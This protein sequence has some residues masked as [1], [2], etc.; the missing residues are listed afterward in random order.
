MFE[1]LAGPIV[2]RVTENRACIWLAA[3]LESALKLSILD[4][5]GKVLGVSDPSDLDESRCRLG[6]NLY[7][8]L[9]QARPCEGTFPENALLHYRIDR[10]EGDAEVPIDLAE[11]GLTY[12]GAQHPSFFLP[13]RLKRILYGSCRKPHGLE[14]LFAADPANAVTDGLSHGDAELERTHADLAL[15]PALLVLGGDQIYADDVAVSL[16]EMLKP[17]ATRLLGY[18]EQIP[19]LPNPA[20][21]APNGRKAA[22]KRAGF[23]SEEADN[24]LLGFGEFAA[25][26]LYA[27]GNAPAWTPQLHL[28][29]K[30]KRK[31]AVESFHATLPKVRRLLAN[32]PTYMIFDDHDVTDDWNITAAWYNRVRDSAA[33]R[34]VTA[35]AL[36]AYW[37][38][39]AW[40]NDPDNFDRDLRWAIE[41]FIADDR[42]CTGDLADR[43]DLQLW[44]H[45]GWG[46]SIPSNPPIV[47]I[48]SRTQRQPDNDYNPPKLLDRYA[49][50]WLRVEW[51]KLKTRPG[52]C[53]GWPVFIAATPVMGFA[54][55]ELI[56]RFGLWLAGTLESYPY[57]RIA[58]KLLGREGFL[59]EKIVEKLDAEAWTSNLDGF[60]D[61]LSTLNERMGIVQCVFLSGDVHYAFTAE[62]CFQKGQGP[63]LS[64]RQL[65]SSALCNSPSARSQRALAKMAKLEGGK[66]EHGAPPLWPWKRWQV[67][68]RMIPSV[69]DGNLGPPIETLCNL[70]VAA[71][72]ASGTPVMHTLL[73]GVGADPSYSLPPLSN[74]PVC[75]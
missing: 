59:A 72:D 11:M 36:A 65:T 44:K 14:A 29:A 48:D 28:E 40:G 30:P 57:V 10:I 32:V 20:A 13:D 9:L 1:I 17:E 51:L 15:R 69:R 45:R 46:F 42:S 47:A 34:R 38:F 55:V 50:D 53:E 56:Q 7:V 60:V 73:T 23:S 68:S 8:Y 5:D 21:M 75:R 3:N 71:F 63:I 70:G 64:C 4:I 66:A 16:L 22:S 27:F 58:E 43:F 26:Y 62:A 54:P 6:A 35:N 33:G 19:D 61:F 49:L 31:K 25:M 18:T 41:S 67:V 37:A 74:P 12:G 39:Q 52:G 2:R 24:H